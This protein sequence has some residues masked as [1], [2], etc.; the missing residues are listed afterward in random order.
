MERK[1][2]RMETM[3]QK[4]EEKV[5]NIMSKLDGETNQQWVDVSY[6]NVTKRKKGSNRKLIVVGNKEG[7]NNG[8]MEIKSKITNLLNKKDDL[9]NVENV[10]ETRSGK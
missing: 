2:E 6:A 3:T 4:T 9:I 8:S 1:L 5:D 10:R 7:H